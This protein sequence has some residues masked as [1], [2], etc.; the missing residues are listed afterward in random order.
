MLGVEIFAIIVV[1]WNY[2]QQKIWVKQIDLVDTR[3]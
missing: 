3:E 2:S 1:I